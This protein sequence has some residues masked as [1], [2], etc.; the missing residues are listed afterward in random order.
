MRTVTFSDEV[1]SDLI[2][3]NFV[4]VWKNIRPSQKFSDGQYK[5]WGEKFAEQLQEG[6]GQTNICTIVAT[7]EGEILYAMQGHYKKKRFIKELQFALS[8]QDK[9]RD[10]LKVAYAKKR[11]SLGASTFVEQLLQNNITVLQGKPLNLSKLEKK[12]SA[13]LR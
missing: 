10:A 2:G 13:G 7:P 11:K 8:L 12:T 5:M 6:V 3:A 4:S 9:D 1:V